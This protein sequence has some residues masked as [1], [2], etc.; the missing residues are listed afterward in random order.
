MLHLYKAQRQL[1]VTLCT[2]MFISQYIHVHVTHVVI[3]VLAQELVQ[4][5]YVIS[6]KYTCHQAI[7]LA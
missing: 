5:V 2:A 4:P 6:T 3:V 1:H 7:N